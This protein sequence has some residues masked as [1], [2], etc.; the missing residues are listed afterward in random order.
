MLGCCSCSCCFHHLP[1]SRPPFNQVC[2][3]LYL[4]AVP[5]MGG[6]QRLSTSPRPCR[7][8]SLSWTPSVSIC[9]L[10]IRSAPQNFAPPPPPPPPPCV[11]S[12]MHTSRQFIQWNPFLSIISRP[13]IYWLNSYLLAR[14]PS[15]PMHACTGT[16]TY[17]RGCI[18]DLR[19]DR[20]KRVRG[21]RGSGV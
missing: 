4:S 15:T 2:L 18:A 9:A 20:H 17:I 6:R 1:H 11:T 13:K 16:H 10:S 8:T 3:Q 14:L 21:D 12:G 19:M 5:R 7:P